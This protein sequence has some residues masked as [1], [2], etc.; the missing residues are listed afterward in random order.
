MNSALGVLSGSGS[1]APP[2]VSRVSAQW[3]SDPCV[4]GLPL[5]S[6]N[7]PR[8][9]ADLCTSAAA[10]RSHGHWP[11][12]PAARILVRTSVWLTYS[13]NTVSGVSE[14]RKLKFR[15]LLLEM[16]MRKWSEYMIDEEKLFVCFTGT[17]RKDD[18]CGNCPTSLRQIT[19]KV[20][21]AT[22]CS[23]S[24]FFFYRLFMIHV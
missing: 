9:P 22:H 12:V 10:P 15:W 11:A 20:T 3:N 7:R 4:S 8:H 14:E 5:L 16:E 18:S 1:C 21:A 13:N 24:P 19:A 23:S 2:V 17:Q 6:R